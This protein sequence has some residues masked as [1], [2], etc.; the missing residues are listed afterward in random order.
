M[1]WTLLQSGN[2][3]RYLTSFHI[4]Q[5]VWTTCRP[6]FSVLEHLYSV[7][8]AHLFSKSIATSTVAPQWKDASIRPVPK[9]VSPQVH[10]DYRPI[11]ITPVLCRTLERVIVREFL[12]PAILAPPT[13]LSFRDQYAFRSIGSTNAALIAILQSITDLLSTN[14]F[15]VV[16]GAD[17]SKASDTIRQDALL[18]KM[19]MLDIPDPIYNRLVD[20]FSG[21]KH[22]TSYGGSVS[23][24]LEISASIIQGSVIGPVSYV[25]SASNLSTVTP[26]NFMFKYADDTYIIIPASNAHSRDAELD[27]VAEWAVNNL[28]LN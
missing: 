17:F 1:T 2:Y 20:Y 22:S 13:T 27:N 9:T 4:Q 10:S 19:A 11:S 7:N 16:I 25:V 3:F 23:Q 24:L 8:L 28:Q 15:V 6:G 5:L 26:G 14:P 18:R 12:Y 21:H